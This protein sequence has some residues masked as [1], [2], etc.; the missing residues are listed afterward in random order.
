[1]PQNTQANY[2]QY[3]PLYL[4][5]TP[6]YSKQDVL[7][8][9][10]IIWRKCQKPRETEVAIAKKI[11]S[12][13]LLQKET[14]KHP[15]NQGLWEEQQRPGGTLSRVKSTLRPSGEHQYR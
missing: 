7:T 4:P 8:A 1:M 13:H 6:V 11:E 12:R 14:A 2:F 10:L 5:Y 15:L 9:T 3:V